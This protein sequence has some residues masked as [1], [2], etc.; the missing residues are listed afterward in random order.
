M[1]LFHSSACWTKRI[2]VGLVIFGSCTTVVALGT[3][4][5]IPPSGVEVF[6]SE[7]IS[8]ISLVLVVFRALASLH[9]ETIFMA[10]FPSVVLDC[11][12]EH[13]VAQHHHEGA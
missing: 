9:L 1:M 3:G 8:C 5:A 12:Q 7:F 2:L 6:L 4:A 13:M 11:L 10:E